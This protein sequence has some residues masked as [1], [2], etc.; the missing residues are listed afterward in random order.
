MR[1]DSFYEGAQSKA[2]AYGHLYTQ[3]SE[4]I[5][6]VNLSSNDEGVMSKEGDILFPGSSTVPFGTAQSNAILL[7]NVKLGGDIII[8]RAKVVKPYA[9]FISYQINAKKEKLYPIT[10]GT[11]ITHMYGKDI[12]EIRYSFPSEEEQLKIG[13]FL[14]DIDNLITLHQSLRLFFLI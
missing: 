11:T 9:P 7:D 14:I 1:L 2:I 12:A 5:S 10:V 4:V 6:H 13:K 8:A 3:Y